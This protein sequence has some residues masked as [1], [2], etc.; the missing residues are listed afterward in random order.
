M[1]KT[2]AT[3]LGAIVL[4]PVLAGVAQARPVDE[5]HAG[6]A[7][8]SNCKVTATRDLGFLTTIQYTTPSGKVR[9]KT[10]RDSELRHYSNY[11]VLEREDRGLV[12]N[13]TCYPKKK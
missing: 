6:S 7:D 13:N 4:M 9:V 10:L 11:I 2:L 3:V 1:K 8:R 5:R 12:V